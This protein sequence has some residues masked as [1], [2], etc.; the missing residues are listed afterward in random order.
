[1]RI[2]VT[3][4]LIN[5]EDGSHIWSER[6]DRELTDVFAIQDEIAQVITSALHVKISAVPA[7]QKRYTPALPAYDALLKGRYHL[8]RWTQESLARS[9]GYFEQAI[10]LDPQFALAH[11]VFARYYNVLSLVSSLPA[12]ETA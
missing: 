7:K 6:Y 4:Q 2:R 3:A 5:A 8:S 10:A 12:H 1:N 11:E 9:K